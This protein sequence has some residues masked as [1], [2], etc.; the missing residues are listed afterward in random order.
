MSVWSLRDGSLVRS[1]VWG[2]RID[3]C[4]SGFTTLHYLAVCNVVQCRTVE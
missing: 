2:N 3:G 4:L 1:P